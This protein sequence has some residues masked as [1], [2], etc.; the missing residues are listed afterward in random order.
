MSENETDGKRCPQC[1]TLNLASA[2][3]CIGCH[4]PLTERKPR[5]RHSAREKALG[6][7]GGNRRP[8]VEPN[9]TTVV[10]IPVAPKPPLNIANLLLR[11]ITLILVVVAVFIGID[12]RRNTPVTSTPIAEV[13]VVETVELPQFD[14]TAT[15]TPA[16][17]ISTATPTPEAPT[18]TPEP[19]ATATPLPTPTL[20]PPYEHAIQ[21]GEAL[22][23]LALRY[24]VSLDSILVNN[25]GLVPESI[26]VGQTILVPRPTAT[27][28]LVP[29][30]ISV[31][32][33]TLVADPE[34][35]VMH[36]IES[37][38]TYIK[39]AQTYS[40]PLDALLQM[41]RLSAD[42]ILQPG[43]RVCIPT[44]TYTIA[45]T[46]LGSADGGSQFGMFRTADRPTLLY[47][48]QYADILTLPVTLQWLAE[49]SLN[50]NE[51]YMLELTNLSDPTARPQRVFTQQSSYQ[52]P[53]TWYADSPNAQ[54]RWRVSY[55][56]VSDE[57]ANGAFVYSYGG[58]SAE[59]FFTLKVE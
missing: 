7:V 50:D 55:V 10:P 26:S 33:Q 11:V 41:N 3:N 44:I 22:F 49:R 6:I 47:P 9:P 35:C 14:A 37:A 34:A 18:A 31:N 39:I 5:R 24:N 59:S 8:V 40:V 46:G 53:A 1:D 17:V 13:S 16:P 52:I 4:K 38:D 23:N 42:N 20:E 54:F 29:I 12:L 45:S 58:P 32:D 51:W 21:E 43:D 48:P 30:E 19:T 28:P 36:E 25:P 15:A 27:P 56:Q 57:R 2:E